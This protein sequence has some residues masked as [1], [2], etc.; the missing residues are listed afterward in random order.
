MK[1]QL[2]DEMLSSS[3]AKGD[4]H[5]FSALYARYLKSIYNYVFLVCGDTEIS[6]EITQSVFVKLWESRERLDTVLCIRSY[7]FKCAKN[8][9]LDHLR[10]EQLKARVYQQI[11]PKEEAVADGADSRIIFNQYLHIMREAINLLPNKRRQIVLMRTEEEL[12]LDEI[13]ADMEISKSVVKKQLY[14]GLNFIRSYIRIQL[15]LV[16]LIFFILFK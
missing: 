3:I 11:L 2:N 7:I 16:I 5:A 4:R 15:D 9:L 8:M 12:S 10:K 13:A 1:R 6:D 14:Q